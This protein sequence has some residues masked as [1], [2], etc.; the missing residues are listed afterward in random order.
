[1]KLVAYTCAAVAVCLPSYALSVS[2]TS[3][4]HAS[5]HYLPVKQ[6]DC[7]G[8]KGTAFKIADG[9]WISVAHV[10]EN[11]GC[12][13]DGKPIGATSEPGDFSIV[14][15]DGHGSGFPINC[16]GFVPGRWYFAAGYAG[17]YEWQ[18]VQRHLATYK[19]SERDG[20]RVLIGTQAVIPGMSGGPILN[21]KG[22]VVGTVN[23]LNLDRPISYSR[24]LKDTSLCK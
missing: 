24:E 20:Y 9:R 16:D 23:M 8:G 19:K 22:E 15:H 13:I 5:V 21:E 1:M 11:I 6:V 2:R 17:G 12:A 3:P 10:T 14:D 7:I 18:T 4:V